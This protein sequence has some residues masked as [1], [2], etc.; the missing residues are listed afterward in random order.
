[1]KGYMTIE[2]LAQYSSFPKR[3]LLELIR[4]RELPSVTRKRKI[5]VKVTDF[6]Y[7]FRRE[8]ERSRPGNPKA[9]QIIMKVFGGQQHESCNGKGVQA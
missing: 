8:K 2:E 9:E 7:W 5:V 4:S 6:D 1:M 3:Q